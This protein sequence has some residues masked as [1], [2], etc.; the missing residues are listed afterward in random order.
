ML[1]FFLGFD[2][3]DD[4]TLIAKAVA[5]ECGLAFISVQGP[6]LINMV[7]WSACFFLFFS[8]IFL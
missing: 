7:S 3:N 5:T 1:V 8:S 6:E 4:K 2:T